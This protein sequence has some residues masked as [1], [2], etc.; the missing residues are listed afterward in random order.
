MP[1]VGQLTH[2]RARP[3]HQPPASPAASGGAS[4]SAA[5]VP[6]ARGTTGTRP[7]RCTSAG[8]A[9]SSR[10]SGRRGR[11]RPGLVRERQGRA[12]AA[13]RRTW[14]S[15]PVIANRRSS[16]RLAS[17]TRHQR[18]HHVR[19]GVDQPGPGEHRY[20]PVQRQLGRDRVG[21]HPEQL[22]RRPG[23]HPRQQ[24][25]Q[26][27][28]HPVPHGRTRPGSRA[29]ARAAARG[30]ARTEARSQRRRLV[31]DYAARSSPA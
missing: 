31:A 9:S 1:V 12:R 21:G 20:L 11:E 18:H 5:T 26:I 3:R 14:P 19:G 23:Q 15:R 13:A 8:R 27:H 25:Q 29:A 2:H 6:R 16:T 30:S 17:S 10:P 4:A 7:C 22:D 28:R 24:D